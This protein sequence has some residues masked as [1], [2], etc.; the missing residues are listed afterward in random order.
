M[1]SM[2]DF[3]ATQNVIGVQQDRA[4]VAGT[5]MLR[6]DP[7]RQAR[8][9]AGLPC[10]ESHRPRQTAAN[11]MRRFMASGTGSERL[12]RSRSF[13]PG[14]PGSAERPARSWSY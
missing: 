7:P 13:G 9:F 2:F 3:T 8:L 6:N 10:S 5:G 11:R 12:T 1:R 4:N 14:Q